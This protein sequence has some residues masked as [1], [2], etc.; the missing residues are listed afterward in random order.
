ML[1]SLGYHA[2]CLGSA[3]EAIDYYQRRRRDIDLV[4]LDLIMP[5]MDGKA[6]LHEL[7][8]ADPAARVVVTSGYSQDASVDAMLDRG[9]RAFLQKPYRLN[10]L[11]EVLT[12][13]LR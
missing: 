11:S 3:R 4:L 2:I 6:V 1:K 9:A 13:A 7:L 8:H 12:A 5:D 10:Q